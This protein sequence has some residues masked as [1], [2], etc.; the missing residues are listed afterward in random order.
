MKIFTFEKD[1][2]TKHDCLK[3]SAVCRPIRTPFAGFAGLFPTSSGRCS[4]AASPTWFDPSVYSA[5]PRLALSPQL[6]TQHSPPIPPCMFDTS[7]PPTSPWTFSTSSLPTPRSASDYRRLDAMNRS[8][9]RCLWPAIDAVHYPSVCCFPDELRG[10]G[11]CHCRHFLR[12][13]VHRG[14][15]GS[16]RFVGC[17]RWTINGAMVRQYVE[18]DSTGKTLRVMRL[19]GSV[20]AMMIGE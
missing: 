14:A 17:R 1:P 18:Q 13:V 16:R 4:R 9:R 15:R 7:L 19:G 10:I 5:V 12:A 20:V 8:R 3:F 2:P 11:G 6:I